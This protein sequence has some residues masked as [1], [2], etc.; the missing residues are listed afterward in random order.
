[1]RLRLTCSLCCSQGEDVLV[2]SSELIYS[3][4]LAKIS[5]P[6]AKS[7]QR[8]FFLFDHQ[9]VCCK[10]V[11]MKPG[12]CCAGGFKWAPP[13]PL[14]FLNSCWPHALLALCAFFPLRSWG[15]LCTWA[16]QSAAGLILTAKEESTAQLLGLVQGYSVQLSYEY[17]HTGSL[18]YLV[19]HL[20]FHL[21][22]VFRK[23]CRFDEQLWA[24]AVSKAMLTAAHV[25][26]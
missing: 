20:N 5:H 13:P 21:S 1:M 24:L 9:L 18:K 19:L 4:E 15:V 3:G 8:M 25:N 26:L 7:Q 17:C 14:C 11:T 6:Q 16:Q 10:K 12:C 2:R 22:V 23:N